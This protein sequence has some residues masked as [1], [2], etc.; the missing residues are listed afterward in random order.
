[1]NELPKKYTKYFVVKKE[2]VLLT[3][4]LARGLSSTTPM[5]KRHLEAPYHPDCLA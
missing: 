1:M 3:F 2:L 4:G 5:D